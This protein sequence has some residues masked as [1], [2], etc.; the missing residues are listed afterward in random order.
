MSITNNIHYEKKKTK[1]T[2]VI[3][4][5]QPPCSKT[6]CIELIRLVQARSQRGGGSE[7]S[8]EPPPSQAGL[9]KYMIRSP[10]TRILV[11][12]SNAL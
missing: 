9:Y 7:E 1:K 4:P 11:T 10:P 8:N 3:V 2:V 6:L 5:E 12:P